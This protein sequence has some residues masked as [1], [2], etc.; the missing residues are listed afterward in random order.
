MEY[1]EKLKKIEALFEGA[2]TA[3]EREAAEL[4]K[5]RIL[6]RFREELSSSRA[7]E[8]TVRLGDRWHKRLFVALCHKYDLRTYRYKNQKYTTTMIRASKSFVD[9]VLWPEFKKYSASLEEFISTAADELISKI[10]EIE[11]DTIVSGQSLP[12]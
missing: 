12:A 1:S 8:Y 7:I 3:G 2:K 10:H 5:R 4:A 9:E 11:E 6:D